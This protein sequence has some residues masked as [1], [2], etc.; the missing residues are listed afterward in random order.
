MFLT[1][2]YNNSYLHVA[3]CVLINNH[4]VLSSFLCIF[5]FLD[6][7]LWISSNNSY[8]DQEF[9]FIFFL[10][11]CVKYDWK[12]FVKEDWTKCKIYNPLCRF[13]FLHQGFDV[14]FV[15]FVRISNETKLT[16][17]SFVIA[18]WMKI[19]LMLLINYI[20]FLQ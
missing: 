20:H 8:L 1:T 3:T 4:H 9:G 12:D 19:L 5:Y 15:L 6:F 2:N 7:F 16:I 18:T 10:R 17:T 11:L 14:F 13:I